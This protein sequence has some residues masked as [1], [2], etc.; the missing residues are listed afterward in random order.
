MH[1][2]KYSTLSHPE[3]SGR[4]NI[5]PKN[6]SESIS[7]LFLI[8]SYQFKNYKYLCFLKKY[9]CTYDLSWKQIKSL[10]ILHKIEK[11]NINCCHFSIS[12][13]IY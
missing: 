1:T 9:N 7:Q 2:S 11:G 10:C 13:R 5:S 12:D 6:I 4:D 3:R 8:I